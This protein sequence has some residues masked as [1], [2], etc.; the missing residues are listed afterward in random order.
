MS[1]G[2]DP[3]TVDE[4]ATWLA[5]KRL[6]GDALAA[7]GRDI[8]AATGLSGA[9]FG[10]LTRLI[11]LGGGSLPQASLLMSLG[12]EK[13]RLS[14]QLTRMD[15]RRLLK[16]IRDA[17]RGAVVE[18]LPLGNERVGP[19]RLIH[20]AAVRRHVLRHLS[21]DEARMIVTI[22]RRLEGA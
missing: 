7:V 18:M 8:E 17:D 16:R 14:H 21:Q 5:V 3:L 22:A 2:G 15:K 19:A 11:D 10:V 20:A 6:G 13:S 9:D 1:M 4:R 12:W